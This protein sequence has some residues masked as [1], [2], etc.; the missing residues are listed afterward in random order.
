MGRLRAFML[1]GLEL[2]LILLVVHCFHIEGTTRFF[3]VLCLAAGGFLIHAW[4]PRPWRAHFFVLLSLSSILLVL[5]W[6]NGAW[7][8][9]IGGGLIALCHLPLPLLVRVLLL[10]LTGVLLAQLRWRFPQPFWP[11]LASMFMFRLIVYLYEVGSSPQRPPLAHTLAYF[12]PLPNVCFTL[13]PVLDFQ[14]FRSTYY[15]DD[16]Y[17]IY[18]TGIA[19]LVRGITHLLLYRV[20]KYYLLPAP[21]HLTDLPHLLLFMA[22]NYAKYLHVSGWFH[23]IIG[24][25]H[26]FGF[27]LPRTHHNYFLASSVSDIWRRINIYWKEFMATVFFW[28]VFFRLRRWGTPVAVIG[29]VLWVFVVTC[30]LHSYQAFWLLRSQRPRTFPI[31]WLS[32]GIAV[33]VNVLL[34]LFVK[35][36]V[37]QKPKQSLA[38][39]AGY[40]SFSPFHEALAGAALALRIMATFLLVSFFWACWTL[41]KFHLYLYVL[42]TPGA[43]TAADGGIMLGCVA[44]G[45]AAGALLRL[46][47]RGMQNAKATMQ[48]ESQEWSAL[49]ILHSAFCLGRALLPAG[50]LLVLVVAGIPQVGVALGPPVAKVL[51]TLRLE[52]P[53]P[54]EA[55]L[56]IQGYYEELAEAPSQAAPLLSLPDPADKKPPPPVYTDMTRPADDFLERELI[57]G[58]SGEVVGKRLTINSLGMR[59]REGITREKPA[60]VCRLAFIGSSIVMGYGV[61]DEKPFPRQLEALLN[62]FPLTPNPS[63]QRGEGGKMAPLSPLGRGV[64]GEGRTPH[65]EVL[66]FGTGKSNGIHRLTLLQR[67]VLAFDPDAIYYVAH[68]DE[69]EGA[70]HHLAMLI[71]RHNKLPAY[72]QEIAQQAGVS[73]GTPLEQGEIR[74]QR[75]AP[76]IVRAVY[77]DIV[78][79]CRQRGTLPV[80]VYLPMSAG[81]RD[82]AFDSLELIELAKQAGFVVLNLDKWNVGR[83]QQAL[84]ADRYHPNAAG[85]QLIAEKLDEALQKRPDALPACARP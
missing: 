1:V 42:A 27:N 32:A 49:S 55:A 2:A 53:T 59:D 15:D 34:E 51:A 61:N 75:L 66:N 47:Q 39:A 78:Q 77:A 41:P 79:Q 60:G 23:I 26:L 29:A 18:H 56:A 85:H 69:L 24:I 54:I 83:A 84:Q 50:V 30:L 48:N 52:A 5:D 45:M 70:V 64:G 44:G 65:I 82:A 13:L 4:L 10:V 6:P 58:W 21:H 43:I 17:A 11:V 28:P 25:L 33:A 46:A 3:P 19:A 35:R 9:A 14:T 20:V 12:F 62:A 68:Q 40:G 37:Q 57:P 76:Q 8:I 73:P 16:D 31:L 81:L 71:E 36:R 7:V 67:K 63:P 80:W 38:G 22:A 72:L 74:L